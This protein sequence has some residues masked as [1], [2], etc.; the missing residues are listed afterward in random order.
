M[1]PGFLQMGLGDSGT[2]LRH[3]TFPSSFYVIHK[4][5]EKF[6]SQKETPLT[7]V[8]IGKSTAGWGGCLPSVCWKFH[9]LLS[10]EHHSMPCSKLIP[11]SQD[12]RRRSH[13]PFQ[14]LQSLKR[15][16]CG[17][18]HC[19]VSQ[20]LPASLH[21][22]CSSCPPLF[23]PLFEAGHSPRPYGADFLPLAWQ[24]PTSQ[25]TGCCGTRHTSL[26]PLLRDRLLIPL[27]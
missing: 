14:D 27:T 15:E 7:Y 16:T 10:M 21:S 25:G 17:I 4:E 18:F 22:H 13:W 20:A 8:M 11:F 2:G 19:N 9:A 1:F 23:I 5:E 6:Y 24:A 26:R 3:S 12:P